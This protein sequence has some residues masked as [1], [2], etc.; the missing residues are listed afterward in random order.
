MPVC[1]SNV[2]VLRWKAMTDKQISDK[3]I[4]VQVARVREM[5]SFLD[6]MDVENALAYCDEANKILQE[7]NAPPLTVSERQIKKILRLREAGAGK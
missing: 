7:Y 5:E 3:Q 4:A 2:S 6:K 1:L